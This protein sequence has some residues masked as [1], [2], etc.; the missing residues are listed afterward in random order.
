MKN[1]VVIIGAGSA[2]FGLGTLAT[3]VR[4]ERLRGGTLALVDLNAEGLGLIDTLAR[5]LNR[6]WGAGLTIESSTQREEMLPG[7]DFVVVAIEVGPREGTWQRDWEIPLQFG[8]RQPYGENGGPGGFAHTLRQVPEMLA[9]ARDM[10][11]LCPDAWLINFT[12]PVPRLCLA[13]SR[14]S[15]IKTV[16]L[17]HQINEA[18]MF[19]GVALAERFGVDVPPGINSNAHPDIWPKARHVADQMKPLIDVKAAG[20]N[21]F[22]WI[23]DLRDRRSGEDLYPAFRE[24]FMALP[25]EFEPLT[26]AVWLATGLCPVPGDSHL[27]EYLPWCHDPQ[28]R[29]WEKYDL[30]LYDWER[31]KVRRDEGWRAIEAMAHGNA[32]IDD[33]RQARSEGAAEIVEG[34]LGFENYQVAVNIPNRGHITN[35]PNGAIVELPALVGGWGIRGLNV[36]PLPEMIAELC[37]REIAVASLTVDAAVSGDR[38]TA[39]QALLLDP[40]IDD[41]DTAH[42]ILDAYQAEYAEYLP[43]FRVTP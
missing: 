1:K 23:L 16:G 41:I 30:F 7:A 25:A 37:R 40:C 38:R 19:A 20:L 12:N 5:R 33:L 17:C 4:S 10:E 8:V 21:H 11:R 36:G 42:A 31:A 32:P 15:R 14:Y 6:E 27:A 9:I 29:P 2:I 35:L 22:T 13:V 26:R 28:T 43:Q 18:Y 34:L 24:A 3:L 39:L